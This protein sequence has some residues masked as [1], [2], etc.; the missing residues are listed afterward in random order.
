M[1]AR[2]LLL[3]A[4]LLMSGCGYNQIQQLDEQTNQMIGNIQAELQRR[5]D[6][7]PNLV[8][9]VDQAAKFESTTQ[10]RVAEARSGLA[11]SRDQMTS[12]LAS[13]DADQIAAANQAVSSNLRSFLTV[14]VEAYPDLKANQNF[15]RLQ[16]ELTETE[17]RI[18]VA[19]RDYN[20]AVNEYNTYIRKFPAVLTAKVTG[21]DP[22]KPFAAD[23][24]ATAAPKVEFSN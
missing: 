22:K 11:A 15:V 18:S 10:T 8:A 23:P 14:S 3:P 5:N 2:F 12:A 13:E 21:A 16:D 6:L 19:R 20:T 1:K 7:I 4:I 24:G 9:T 17:N